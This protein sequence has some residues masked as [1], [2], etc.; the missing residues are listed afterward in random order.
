MKKLITLCCALLIS[1]VSLAQK[2]EIKAIEKALKSNNFASAKSS[3]SAADNL[4]ANMDDKT[5]A[6]YYFLKAQALYANGAASDPDFEASVKSLDDL[7]DLE[8]KMGKLKYTKSA[9]DLKAKMLT[10]VLT[11]A[12]KAYASKQ[13]ELA[14]NRF[15]K[16]YQLSPSDTTYLYFSASAALNAQNYDNALEKYI[17]LKNLGYKDIR[18]VY[19]AFN[20]ETGQE[21]PFFDKATRDISLKSN[22]YEK[23]R[24]EKTKSKYAEIVK[25]IAEILVF[26]DKKEEALAAIAEAKKVMPNDYNLIISEG[27]TYYK[28][29]NKEKAVELFKEALSMDKENPD[30]NYNVGVISLNAKDYDNAELYLKKALEY[31]PDYADAAY[32]LSVISID[33]GNAINEELNKLGTSAADN[34]KYDELK[35]KKTAFYAQG[36]KSLEDYL[37]NNP[38]SKNLDLLNQ[39]KSIYSALGE[40]AKF[41]AIKEKIA[42]IESGN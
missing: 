4:M 9:N 17:K 34:L 36:A 20:T 3:V 39:L 13:F 12:D 25:F 29:G 28:L 38:N 37:S 5:K 23:P 14:S 32:N 8:S 7:K 1:T 31:K 27:N 16:A 11:K 30:L 26:Q 21:E 15:E 41:K 35:E 2:N 40:M 33:K 10:D 22:K 6:K 24:S 42:L 19:Y 18:M